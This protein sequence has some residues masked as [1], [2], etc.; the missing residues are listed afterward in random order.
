M[1][2][3]SFRDF[4]DKEEKPEVG[5]VAP[6]LISDDGLSLKRG[7]DSGERSNGGL[8]STIHAAS[9]SPTAAEIDRPGT[10]HPLAK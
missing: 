10:L 8:P 4:E 9:A 6:Q 1:P 5:S 7:T 2:H 3:A